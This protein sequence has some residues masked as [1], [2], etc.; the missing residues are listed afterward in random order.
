MYTKLSVLKGHGLS[1]IRRLIHKGS[2]SLGRGSASSIAIL[3]SSVPWDQMLPPPPPEA[4]AAAAA[5]RK[6]VL[7]D[8][9]A[10]HQALSIH[11]P[12]AID[13]SASSP[14]PSFYSEEVDNYASKCTHPITLQSL[15]TMCEA[16]L[17]TEKLLQN[18]QYLSYERPVRYAKRVKLFQH[19]PFIVNT[20]PYIHDVYV[21]YF[22]NFEE[23]HNHPMV[24]NWDD[25]RGFIQ[26][27]IRHSD[28]LKHIMPQIARGFY[29]TRMYFGAK[30]RKLFLDQLI[31]MRI[32]LR[33][34]TSQHVAMYNKYLATTG[35]STADAADPTD[36]ADCDRFTG[37]VDNNIVLCDF[38]HTC[39]QG[40][41]AL[42]EMALGD[43]PAFVIDGDTRA[44]FRYIPSHL[45]YMV[46][47]LLKNAFRSSLLQGADSAQ[48]TSPP[49]VLIT[50][51]RG[52]GKVAIRIRDRGGGIP[53][54]I[55]SKVF[56]YSF[57][58]AKQSNAAAGN[59]QSDPTTDA[60]DSAPEGQGPFAGLGFGLPM[61]KIYA[62]FFGGSLHLISLEEYGCD[63]FLEL[64][65]IKADHGPQIHI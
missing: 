7:H 10:R 39:A 21:K 48:E 40:V 28:T 8:S 17:T 47:E 16:P 9:G 65:S 61:T 41:Q 14:E 31:T 64:P 55:H 50:V 11:R 18:A 15:L 32:G 25:Q 36:Q 27:L 60:F 52:N 54:R 63:V 22:R 13:P 44:A 26:M 3:G 12:Q 23:S 43:A 35:Q 38:V 53:R 45:E 56:D 57:T 62:E 33:L 19:L 20:N 58:T 42:C 5:P 24:R 1:P 2:A 49:P 30:E 59:D 34:L 51:S 46:I 4:A 29:E 6:K 37:I